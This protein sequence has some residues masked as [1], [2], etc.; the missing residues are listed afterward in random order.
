MYFQASHGDI[1]S[2]EWKEI[3]RYIRTFSSQPF[4]NEVDSGMSDE[5]VLYTSEEVDEEEAQSIWE[6]LAMFMFIDDEEEDDD[7][8]GIRF[9]PGELFYWNGTEVNK[10][11]KP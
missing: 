5:V 6:Y 7:G 11:Q 9:Q 2:D 3:N 4:L 8:S 10:K 1:R